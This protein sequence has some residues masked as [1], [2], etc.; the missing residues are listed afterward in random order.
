MSGNSERR[1]FTNS[2]ETYNFMFF[3]MR[4]FFLSPK[5][6]KPLPII[7]VLLQKLKSKVW[8]VNV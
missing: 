5:E 1:H 8:A 2:N 7:S 3:G 4:S 6:I